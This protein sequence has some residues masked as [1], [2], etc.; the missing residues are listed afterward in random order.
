MDDLPAL[1]LRVEEL[2][3]LVRNHE[4]R[5]PP[6]VIHDDP[7]FAYSSQ[8]SYW[9]RA[10][11]PPTPNTMNSGRIGVDGPHGIDAAR[12]RAQVV[13]LERAQYYDPSTKE[14]WPVRSVPWKDRWEDVKQTGIILII[15][16]L[17]VNG[18]VVHDWKY[19][20]N[21]PRW[22]D[23]TSSIETV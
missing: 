14:G 5:L 6:E 4:T 9:I 8:L 21:R 20:N 1:N 2:E 19:S 12:T 3:A 22:L 15:E 16:V 10:L 13:A 7:N 18:Q 17:E 11:N 23:E